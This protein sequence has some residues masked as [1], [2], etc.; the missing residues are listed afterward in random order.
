MSIRKMISLH[1][2]AAGH[3]NQPLSDAAH[4]LMYCARMCISCADACA[5]EK[6]DMRDCIRSCSDCADVCEATG[7]A[8]TGGGEAIQGELIRWVFGQ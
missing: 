8:H 4:H 3:V 6:M 2:N 1:P 5:A 7:N